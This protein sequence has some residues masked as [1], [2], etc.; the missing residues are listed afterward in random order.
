MKPREFLQVDPASLH[1]PGSRREG[2][3]PVKLR[4]QFARYGTSIEGMRP[5]EVKR[6]TDGELVIYDGVTRA[7]RVAKYLPGNLITV[8]AEGARRWA[9]HCG[10]IA[11]TATERTRQDLLAALAQ[12]SRIRPE[13]RL[14]QTL[15]NL[16]M[17]AGRIDSG[18]VWDLED[19]EALAAAMTLIEQHSEVESQVA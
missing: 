2:A 1:L 5:P 10:R 7:T 3:D 13:W 17:T 19:D 4:R 15:A 8:E 18:G 9:A 16:A 14:G 11:M 6:G 12:L